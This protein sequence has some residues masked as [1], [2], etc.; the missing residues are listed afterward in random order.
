M[1]G[2]LA[3]NLFT[4]ISQ[5]HS[6]QDAQFLRPSHHQHH[7]EV[8]FGLSSD[9]GRTMQV[10]LVYGNGL[11]D[12]RGAAS[13]RF[14]AEYCAQVSTAIE[15][16]GSVARTTQADSAAAP[17]AGSSARSSYPRPP[18]SAGLPLSLSSLSPPP[19][20]PA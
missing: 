4:A 19:H 7:L 15:F 14:L 5:S 6:L 9:E 11:V 3:F 10:L 1:G 18:L 13:Y 17:S 8:L 20:H 16:L 2:S 12:N